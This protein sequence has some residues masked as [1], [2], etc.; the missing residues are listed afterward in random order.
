MS[1][2]GTVFIPSFVA[3]GPDIQVRLRLLL[4]QFERLLYW[5]S[6]WE[7]FMKYAV[8]MGSGA[9]TYIP[10]FIKISSR[11]HKLE[12]GG[13]TYTLIH[14]DSKVITWAYFYLHIFVSI[15]LRW[16]LAAFSFSWSFY[17][18]SQW[19]HGLRHEISSPTRTLESWFRIPLKAWMSVCVYSV[20]LLGSGLATG[21]S[22][23]Q[24][25]LTTV[26]D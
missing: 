21:W 25:V 18:P 12:G 2:A 14:P 16:A 20:F 13:Y 1:H 24:G 6:W 11:I 3:I 5:Y 8:E 22:S 19:P 23:A 26:L 9:M 7:R 17:S 15:V 4:Q 10:S